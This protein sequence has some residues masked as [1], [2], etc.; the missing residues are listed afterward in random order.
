MNKGAEVYSYSRFSSAKQKKGGSVE[1]QL[2]YARKVAE[3][4]GL[5]L[6]KELMM[7]D[8]GLSAFHA[9][10]MKRGALGV[11]ID[12]V[13]GGEIAEGSVLIIESLDRLS[14]EQ[15]LNAQF[16]FIELVS[17]GIT[18][19]TA[20]DSQVYNRATISENSGTMFIT[21][22][23]MIRAHEE[24]L[25]KQKRSVAA[26][27]QQVEKFQKDGSGNV[28]GSVPFWID[29]TASGY[30]LNQRAGTV[31]TI[32]DL[33]VNKRLGINRIARELTQKAIETPTGKRDSW[34]A[35]SIKNILRNSA[36]YGQKE[37]EVTSL[38][39]GVNDTVQYSLDKYY[40]AL[41]SK[42][43]F[44][45]ID[46]INKAKIASIGQRSNYGDNTHIITA[47][48]KGRS[49]CT[50][51]KSN[52]TGQLQKQHT[53]A[54]EYTKTVLR[55]H[56]CG[57]KERQDCHASFKSKSLENAFLDSSLI[58]LDRKL[59]KPTSNDKQKIVLEEK[60]VDVKEKLTNAYEEKFSIKKDDEFTR[61]IIQKY[62]D[63]YSEEKEEI[64]ESLKNI[65]YGKV[66]IEELEELHKV[67]IKAKDLKN[68]EERT[69]VKQSLMQIIERIEINFEKKSLKAIFYDKRMLIVN[70][71]NTYKMYDKEMSEDE[72]RHA[73]LEKA[74]LDVTFSAELLSI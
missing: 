57:H 71:D 66:S 4:Y 17:R 30:E 51:C 64:E 45:L 23:A 12:K 52:V 67:I 13:K 44:I 11:F 6:N 29:R 62:I 48:G 9:Q 35:T 42:D 55:L 7:L 59:I 61:N 14:R 49:I 60:L 40:P 8:E 58:L 18:I 36:L 74:I 69:L 26:I 50:H 28:H 27:K 72:I 73:E 65:N 70:S 32:I 24:S 34:G 3:E 25:T 63:Q 41:I 5:T 31:R 68:S 43:D 22:G 16:L 47:W 33:Y 2:D 54:G 20:N 38:V 46:K 19:I 21:L 37:F 53:R 1:R 10:H 39:N 15:L 56:C